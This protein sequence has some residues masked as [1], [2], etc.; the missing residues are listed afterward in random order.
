LLCWCLF[1]PFLS[2]YIITRFIDDSRIS[3]IFC[4]NM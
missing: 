2:R 3:L 1:S 4:Y